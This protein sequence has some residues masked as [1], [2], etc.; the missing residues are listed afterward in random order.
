MSRA[1][2]LAVYSAGL[3]LLFGKAVAVPGDATTNE[4]LA[5]V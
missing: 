2:P 5:D 4:Q 3:A 1:A